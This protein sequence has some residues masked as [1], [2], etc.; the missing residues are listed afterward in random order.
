MAEDNLKEWPTGGR[1]NAVVVIVVEVVPEEDSRSS[2][3]HFVGE[4]Y[5]RSIE[6][7]GPPESNFHR[8]GKEN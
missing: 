8:Y 5:F 3:L 7:M 4:N 6:L 2:L 1:R